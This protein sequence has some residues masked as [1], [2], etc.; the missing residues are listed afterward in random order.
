MMPATSPPLG[1]A[2]LKGFIERELPEWEVKVVDL[3]LW[4]LN[5]L[6]QGIQDGNIGITPESLKGICPSTASLLESARFLKGKSD[7]DFYREPELY[8]HYAGIFNRFVARFCDYLSNVCE[9]W[10]RGGPLTPL[11]QEMINVVLAEKPDFIGLSMIFSQQLHIGAMLGRY[12]RMRAGKK[13]FFGGSVFT[14]GS[15]HFIK[16][17]PESADVIVTGDGEESLYQLLLHEGEVT[18][19]VPGATF[20]RNGEVCRTPPFFRKDIDYYG[21]PNFSDLDLFSYYSP[22]PVIPLLLSRGCYWRKCTFCVHYFSAGDTYRIHSFDLIMKI[23]RDFGEQGIRNFSFVDEMV[24]PAHFERFA[25]ALKQAK[26]DIAYYALSKPN[27]QFTP[28]VLA[29]MAESGCKYL[30]WG[31]ESGAQRVLDLMDKGTKVT[32]LGTIFKDAHAVGIANHLYVICGFPTETTEEYAD[33]IRFLD[34]NKDHIYATHRSVFGLEAGSP[35]Y[36]NQGKFGIT[37]V[38]LANENPLGGRWGYKVSSGVSME[39]AR[40]NFRKTLPF[41]KAFNPYAEMLESFRDHA[42]LV[43]SKV[44]RRL[45]PEN[46]VFPELPRLWGIFLAYLIDLSEL[47][48]SECLEFACSIVA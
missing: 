35:I 29:T 26:L 32:E 13:V 25:A 3:N 23:L 44:S 37:E 34:E 6:F 41:L 38:W 5:R 16:W 39:E 45:R 17:Y 21:A 27:R 22:E 7:N 12:F 15:E 8:N 46:R 33:T 4:L 1:V 9:A 47:V 48:E 43:Y 10:Q 42:L 11:L 2:M 20:L 14:E 30:L 24:A 19:E 36:K 40:S 28:R 31:F 18:D